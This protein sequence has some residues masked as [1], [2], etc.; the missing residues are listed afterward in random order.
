MCWHKWTKWGEPM[1]YKT[2]YRNGFIRDEYIQE[3]KCLKCGLI[4]RSK[5]FNN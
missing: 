4:K 5:I 1:K 3:K 2:E